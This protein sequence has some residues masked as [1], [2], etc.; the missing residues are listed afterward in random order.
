MLLPKP[1]FRKS[2]KAWYLQVARGE[3][4]CLGKTKADAD[5]RYRQWLLE[6]AGALPRTDQ[7]KLT[8]AEIGQEFLDHSQKHNDPRTYDFY[9]YFIVPFVERFGEAVAFEFLPRS[10]NKWLDEHKGWKGSR[11]CAIIA[12]KRMFNWAVT[13]KILAHNPLK[14]VQKPPRRRRNRI[15]TPAEREYVFKSIRDEQF[16]EFVF[17]MLDTG[18]RPS[19]VAKVTA[20]NVARDFTYWTIDEHKTDATG[21]DRIVYLSPA[22]QKLTQKLVGLYTDGPLFRST[23]RKEGVRRPWS[24][25]G[26]RCRFR[27]LRKK[28]REQRQ[29]LSPS[30]RHEIPDL[31]GVN[32]YTLRHTFTTQALSNGLS[33]P[34]VASLL[35]H[36]STK[37]L[38]EHYNHLDQAADVLRDAAAKA[39]ILPLVP[40][41]PKSLRA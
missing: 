28:A 30:R 26:I 11:R 36:K 3:Q 29:K 27:S 5:R 6:N 40:K 38:D 16:R 13:E 25:N 15:L 34:I 39:V 33:A 37:M 4:L 17:A 22:M 20:A 24:R 8:V 12:V 14:D 2:K 35:G 18:C 32:A 31:S 10:F 19:E 7:N 23:R 1:W 41:K 9:R 21:N